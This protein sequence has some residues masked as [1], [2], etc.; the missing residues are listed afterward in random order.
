MNINKEDK[1]KYLLD[2]YADNNEIIKIN[3]KLMKNQN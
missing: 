1:I 2:I 3:E